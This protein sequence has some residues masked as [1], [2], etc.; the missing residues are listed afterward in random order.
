MYIHIYIFKNSMLIGTRQLFLPNL[1][2]V[3][4]KMTLFSLK[5]NLKLI[6]SRIHA[7]LPYFTGGGEGKSILF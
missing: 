4:G 3:G 7:H 5:L 1:L 2:P 6:K